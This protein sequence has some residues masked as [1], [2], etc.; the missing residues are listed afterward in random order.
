MV[1]RIFITVISSLI[2]GSLMASESQVLGRTYEIVEPDALAE[3]EDKVAQV[4]WETVMSDGLARNA[5]AKAVSLPRAQNDRTRYHIPY[6]TAE[7]DVKDQHGK[8]IYPKGFQFNPLEHVRLP[9]RLMFISEADTDWA[10]DHLK[11]TDMIM[12]TSGDYRNIAV[13]LQRPVFILTPPVKDRLALQFVPSIVTQ[14]GSTLRIEE[15]A[16]NL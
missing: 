15:H 7:F 1:L 8:I 13:T 12:I 10:K 5:A 3:I 11:E 6:Y 4:D 14:E 2:A 9:Q 16:I